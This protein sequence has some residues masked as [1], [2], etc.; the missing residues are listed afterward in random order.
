MIG[1]HSHNN[2]FSKEGEV[3]RYIREHRKFSLKQAGEGLNLKA[4]DVDHFEHGR[5]FYKP[6]EIEAF[7]KIYNFSAEHF[8]AILEMKLLNKVNFNLYV[9]K[10]KC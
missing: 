5:R 6:E 2:R 4:Q 1:K 7:L 9:I 10:H 8:D 3:L